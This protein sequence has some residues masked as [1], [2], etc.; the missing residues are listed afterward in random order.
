LTEIHHPYVLPVFT[1]RPN[2]DVERGLKNSLYSGFYNF[3]QFFQESEV[4]I[5]E[6]LDKELT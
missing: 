1:G 4:I 5:S 6:I 3:W 2:E